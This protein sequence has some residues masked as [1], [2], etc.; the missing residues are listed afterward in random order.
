VTG[1][2]P[3]DALARGGEFGETVFV[4]AHVIRDSTV[5][6]KAPNALLS[7]QEIEFLERAIGLGVAP[8]IDR[9]SWVWSSGS[10]RDDYYM[11]LDTYRSCCALKVSQWID[12]GIQGNSAHPI[13][14][15]RATRES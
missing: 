12:P 14:R 10:M 1:S 13:S 8:P 4:R 9:D 7:R 11:K 6:S 2:A 5:E 3:P 15:S